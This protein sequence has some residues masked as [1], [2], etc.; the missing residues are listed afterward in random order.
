[1]P[2]QGSVPRGHGER[3]AKGRERNHCRPSSIVI[4]LKH[5]SILT[6]KNDLPP[7]LLRLRPG[8]LE[9]RGNLNEVTEDKDSSNT[10]N[11]STI[12]G[13]RFVIIN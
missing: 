2:V 4:M 10:S 1:M 3:V 6:T 5:R 11:G 7:I 8:K 9:N 13:R 12:Q